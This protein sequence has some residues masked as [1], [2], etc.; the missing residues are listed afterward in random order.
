MA[1]FAQELL[2]AKANK[3]MEFEWGQPVVTQSIE[4]DLNRMAGDCGQSWVDGRE[5]RGLLAKA[6]VAAV[7]EDTPLVVRWAEWRD[8]PDK[9]Q[10]LQATLVAVVTWMEHGESTVEAER[11][12]LMGHVELGVWTGSGESA[13]RTGLIDEEP[14]LSGPW[15]GEDSERQQE[16]LLQ[17]LEMTV[18]GGRSDGGQQP[19]GNDGRS[20]ETDDGEAN[21]QG[22]RGTRRMDGLGSNRRG[23]RHQQ[24]RTS[25]SRSPE[26]R[27]QQRSRSRSRSRGLQGGPPEGQGG[28]P[29]AGGP[30]EE[31]GAEGEAGERWGAQ[32]EQTLKPSALRSRISLQGA[33]SR[34]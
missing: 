13:P 1:V 32:D 7:S 30:E 3:S 31:P 4:D 22:R 33:P 15:V 10:F 14:G 8:E 26:R 6:R 16:E 21:D 29:E 17:R 28:P 9:A 20:G 5:L 19:D 18:V 12:P 11:V 2:E 27:E 34:R 25:R 24:A 23:P